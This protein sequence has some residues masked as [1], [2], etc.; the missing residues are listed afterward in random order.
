MRF[1]EMGESGLI[2]QVLAWIDEP[3]LRGRAVD[4]L[5]TAIYNGLRDAGIEIPFPQRVV[6]L[7]SEREPRDSS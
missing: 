3:A 1:R 4:A 6:H 5:N 7:R 2:F